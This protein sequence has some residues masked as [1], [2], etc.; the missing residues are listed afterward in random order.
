MIV[1]FMAGVGGLWCYPLEIP[2]AR[3][4]PCIVLHPQFELVLEIFLACFVY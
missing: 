4:L 3:G 2:V 1:I